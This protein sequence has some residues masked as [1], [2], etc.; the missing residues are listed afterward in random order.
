MDERDPPPASARPASAGGRS[1]HRRASPRGARL[2]GAMARLA[3]FSRRGN[4]PQLAWTLGDPGPSVAITSQRIDGRNASALCVCVCGLRR[5]KAWPHDALFG[6]TPRFV[7]ALVAAQGGAP[8]P[9][10][11][12]AHHSG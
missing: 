9:V 12:R 7:G 3:A 6:P 8:E 2:C 10:P 4:F 11:P 5:P 1:S